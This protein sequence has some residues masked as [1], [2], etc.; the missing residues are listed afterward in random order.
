MRS[1][2]VVLPRRRRTAKIG[3]KAHNPGI[4]IIL[5][6]MLPSLAAGSTRPT[7]KITKTTANTKPAKRYARLRFKRNS[8]MEM[9]KLSIIMVLFLFVSNQVPTPSDCQVLVLDLTHF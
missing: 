2:G 6:P 1:V 3:H 4:I 9:V 5:N 7:K 8:T